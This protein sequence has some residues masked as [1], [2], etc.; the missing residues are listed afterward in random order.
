MI[1]SLNQTQAIRNLMLDDQW[2]VTIQDDIDGLP[3]SI[4]DHARPEIVGQIDAQLGRKADPLRHYAKL[5]D[6]EL[7]LIGW[8]EVADQLATPGEQNALAL[9]EADG[10]EDYADGLPCEVFRHYG[11]PL[12]R[13]AY[14]NGYR[15]ARITAAC[16]SLGS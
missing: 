10:R 6:I 4:A 16:F 13:Q 1:I 5:G 15:A 2:I 14:L 9:A 11:N 8:H 3:D 12:T 7:Y